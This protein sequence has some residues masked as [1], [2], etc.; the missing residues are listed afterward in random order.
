MTSPVEVVR[1]FYK[2]LGRGD[3]SAVIASLGPEL[4]WTE[5]ESFPYY[6]GTWR[7]PREVVDNLLVPLARDWENFSVDVDDFVAEGERVVSFG[8]YTGTYRQTGRSMSAPFA[9]SWTVRGGRLSRFD[10]YTDTAKV[11]AAL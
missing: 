9:H 6:G 10:M 1:Q 11:L 3:I 5:A 7:S 8:T 2:A 4:E